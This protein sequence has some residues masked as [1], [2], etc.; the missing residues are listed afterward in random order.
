VLEIAILYPMLQNPFPLK[1]KL[2][3]E[4]LPAGFVR[5]ANSI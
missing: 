4:D 1:A 3:E 2:G 5:F